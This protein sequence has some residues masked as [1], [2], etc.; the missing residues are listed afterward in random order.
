MKSVRIFRSFPGEIA[1]LVD[2]ISEED[3][4]SDKGVAQILALFDNAC[5]GF[6]NIER[7]SIFDKLFYRA[8]EGRRAACRLMSL[9]SSGVAQLRE[10]HEGQCPPSPGQPKRAGPPEGVHFVGRV[11]GLDLQVYLWRRS[12]AEAWQRPHTG[13]FGSRR[14]QSARGLCCTAAPPACP[15]TRRKC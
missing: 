5:R 7:D 11:E 13:G 6:W 12:V 2:M 8:M 4:R 14:L 15:H 3:V 1:M 9:Q 10:R